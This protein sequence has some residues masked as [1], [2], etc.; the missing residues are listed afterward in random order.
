MNKIIKFGIIGCGRISKQHL[1]SIENLPQARLI[2]VC[3]AKEDRAKEIGTAHQV[4]WYK[5]YHNLLKRND[6]DVVSI[7]TPHS[8]HAPMGMDVAKAGK[9]ALIEKPLGINLKEAD[10]M[11]KIFLKLKKKIFPVLQVRFNPALRL[12]KKTIAQKELGRINNAALVIR[13]TRPQDY[14]DKVDWHGTKRM[15][16]GSFLSQGIHYLDA[17]QWLL[18]PVESIF[19]KKDRVGHKN[20]EVEDIL[21]AIMKFKNGAYATIEFTTCTYPRNLE[22]SISILGSQGS[23]KIGGQAINEI[24]LWEVKNRPKPILPPMPLIG[25]SGNDLFQGVCPNHI[26]V[27]QEVIKYFSNLPGEH[28]DALEARK[29]LEIIEAIY[30]STKTKRELFL[31]Q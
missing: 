27:Y 19:A 3:D 15:E 25:I 5:N 9:H 11:L 28:T 6:I 23:I 13:W 7:C 4:A 14:Y 17:L 30:N 20:I 31:N 29:S 24:E 8:L 21:I 1:A 18:G 12:A 26:F 16:G 10:R 22:C 2:A